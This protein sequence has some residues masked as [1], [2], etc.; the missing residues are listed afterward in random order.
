MFVVGIYDKFMHVK[1]AGFPGAYYA[2][3]KTKLAWF[4]ARLHCNS[5]KHNPHLAVITTEEE[6]EAVTEF[7]TS[8]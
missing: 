6:Q 2:L 4:D 3:I 7:L 5:L 1:T 8:G